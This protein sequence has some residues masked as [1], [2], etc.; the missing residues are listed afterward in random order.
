MTAAFFADYAK[1]L[2]VLLDEIDTAPENFRSFDLHIDL[3]HRGLLFVYETRRKMGQTDSIYY[4]RMAKTGASKQISQKTANDAVSGFFRH[5]QFLALTGE[6]AGADGAEGT[7]V[8]GD[9]PTCAIAFTYRR[10]GMEK[11]MSMRLIFLGF[12]TDDGA[13]AYATTVADTPTLAVSRPFRSAR[14]WEWK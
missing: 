14:V 13:M 6:F 3:A 9:H 5:G 7:T 12:S 10:T 1:D 4:A 8:E 2:K 11:A